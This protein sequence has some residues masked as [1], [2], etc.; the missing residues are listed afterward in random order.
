MVQEAHIPDVPKHGWQN[1][2]ESQILC[3]SVEL[4]LAMWVS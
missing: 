2:I 1:E 3:L 4:E